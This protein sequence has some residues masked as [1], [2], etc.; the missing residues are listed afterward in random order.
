VGTLV[1]ASGI[2]PG[3]FGRVSV[4][5]LCAQANMGLENLQYSP[6]TNAISYIP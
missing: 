3:A 6:G 5:V 1:S 4:V 2:T